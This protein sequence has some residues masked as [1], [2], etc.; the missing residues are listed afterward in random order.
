MSIKPAFEHLESAYRLHF[1][2]AFKTHY[3]RPL[4]DGQEV[5]A[6]IT[7]G[8]DDV[9][10]RHDYHL[11]DTKLSNDHLRVLLSLKPSRQYRG[12]YRC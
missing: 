6:A 1:Y 4:F 10:N 7:T 5:Q 8:V 9:C 12:P 3:L 2:L 11:L